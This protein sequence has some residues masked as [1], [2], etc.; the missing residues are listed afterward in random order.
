ML[1]KQS[2]ISC[3]VQLLYDVKSKQE[4]FVSIA[5][6]IVLVINLHIGS[7][8]ECIDERPFESYILPF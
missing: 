6:Y 1:V 8:A 7:R 4:F 2:L 3:F 5:L